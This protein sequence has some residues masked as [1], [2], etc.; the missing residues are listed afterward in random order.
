[1]KRPDKP[2]TCPKCGSAKVAA[3]LYGLPVFNDDL[4]RAI[5]AGEIAL[6]G[7][8]IMGDDPLWRCLECKHEFGKR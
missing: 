2:K 7:C 6:G 4:E 3:I 5:D 1:M 8:C